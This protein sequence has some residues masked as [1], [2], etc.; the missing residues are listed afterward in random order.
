MKYGRLIIGIVA[1]ITALWIILGEQMSGASADAVVNAPV[2][3][4]RAPVAGNLQM[5]A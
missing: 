4:V 5:A 1:V 3:T 2:V